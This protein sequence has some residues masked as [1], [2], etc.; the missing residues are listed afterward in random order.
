MAEN[1]T[2]YPGWPNNFDW[3]SLQEYMTAVKRVPLGQGLMGTDIAGPLYDGPPHPE[4]VKQWRERNSAS[5]SET[6]CEFK[7]SDVQVLQACR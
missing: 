7:L 4:Y 5:V 1:E 3:P 6:A 2:K